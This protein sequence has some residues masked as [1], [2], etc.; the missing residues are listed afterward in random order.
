M[1]LL[2]LFVNV[3]LRLIIQSHTTI[4]LTVIFN[5]F[6]L[7]FL[8]PLRH[9]LYL[10][11]M[12]F[13]TI[14]RLIL[15]NRLAVIISVGI[16][17]IIMGALIP[18]LEFNYKPTPLLPNSDSLLIQHREFAKQFGKGENIMVIGVQDSNFF[19]EKNLKQW[20]NLE[21]NLLA[22]DGV[23]QVLSIFDA[24]SLEK[25]MEK[26]VFTFNKIFPS[27]F[28]ASDID[29]LKTV[30]LSLPFYD[31]LL[32]NKESQ[33]YLMMVVLR[34]DKISTTIRVPFM[35][36]LISICKQ[37]EDI[38]ENT[39]RYSG[40][41]YIRITIGD[42]IKGEMFMFILLAVVITSVLI[43]LLF[44]SFRIMT[45]IML[46]VAVSVIWGLGLMAIL[47][48]QI[49]LLTAVI[50]PLIIVISVPNCIYLLNKYHNEYSIHGNKIKALQRVIR[51]IGSATFVSNLTTA[52]G[53]GTLIF[54]SIGILN[55][56]GLVAAIDI[57]AV[58][59]VSLLLVP[60][61]FSYLP[62]PEPRHLQHLDSTKVKNILTRVISAGL[63][64]RKMVYTITILLTIIG[65]WGV[66]R[67]Q[68]L[69]FMVDDIPKNH[70]VYVDLKYFEKNFSGVMPLEIVVDAEKPKGVMQ[71]KTMRQINML[72]NKLNEYT[73]LSKPL[74]IVEAA[75]FARQAYYNGNPS[76]YKMPIG[77]E[78]AFIMSYLPKDMGRGELLNRFVDS[79]G[80][81]T[82]IIYNVADI[83]SIEI[84]ALK[85]KI[86]ADVDTIFK[87]D[88][89]RVYIT[90]GSII[91]ANGNDYLV[92]SLFSSLLAAIGIIAV[93][94]AWMF[95]K[96]KMVFLSILPNLIPLLLTA[97]AMG[98]LGIAL[99][100]STVIVFSI[101]F[102]ISV[103]N[104]IHYLTKYRQELVRT[105][106]NHKVSIIC[107]IR[108]TGVSMI[109]NLIVLFFGFGI[110]VASQFGGTVSLGILVS[111]T[112][113]VALFSN[114]V[115]LPSLLLSLS[116]NNHESL[117]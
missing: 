62:P 86:T 83:G 30:A 106:N 97:A 35:K 8:L 66:S 65:F 45:F 44:K 63:Y 72:Q 67:V 42:M 21:K 24:F 71:E 2:K 94:M 69:G 32:Y 70:P 5:V 114:L 4:N 39:L 54:T 109:Y 78:R 31:N 12:F 41:P 82:R 79:T 55:E 27:N 73:V 116:K 81:L 89:Q 28:N 6:F 84:K 80:R 85:E 59:V 60:T 22:V 92:R 58:F 101:A 99:K 25:D 112:L 95:K 18:T 1:V 26:K 90:G 56:F 88:A 74:S 107:A 52:A 50:P 51:K 49:T 102:G 47:G 93:F 110:F 34:Y 14:A 16:I 91:A 113:L 68:S 103:D 38:T 15:R 48:F 29:S 46:V 64:H 100:P 115:L 108:E 98:F 104:S 36:E 117:E 87:D 19:S 23:E 75:K 77:P 76:Q 9:Y 57:M 20:Q 53:F 105:K 17:T 3:N 10:F 61:I 40:L 7:A 37:Y 111:L 43:Y 11:T 13:Q 96:G 33:V